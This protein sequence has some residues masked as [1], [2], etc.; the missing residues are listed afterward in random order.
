MNK[1][2][3]NIL[4]ILIII[5]VLVDQIIKVIS[6]AKGNISIQ[7]DK[8]NIS[9]ILINIIASTII[10]RYMSSKNSFIKLDSRILLSLTLA[11]IIS[12]TIDMIWAKDVITYIEVP[13]FARINISYIYVAI[14]WIGMAIVLTRFTTNRIKEKRSSNGNKRNNS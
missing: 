6:I 1:K 5:L 14:T 2:E 13:S 8:D 12:N 3:R 10:L 9:Y 4:V 7:K 11:G